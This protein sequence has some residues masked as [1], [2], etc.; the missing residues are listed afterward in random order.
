MPQTGSVGT[1][2]RVLS[3]AASRGII[4]PMR[5]ECLTILLGALLVAGCRTRE[6]P[7]PAPGPAPTGDFGL[8][9]QYKIEVPEVPEELLKPSPPIESGGSPVAEPPKGSEESRAKA[10]PSAQT[11]EPSP[12]APRKS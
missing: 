10:R 5:R 8:P 12:P 2:G 1:C 11:K 6:E 9:L 3:D 4:Q 7:K